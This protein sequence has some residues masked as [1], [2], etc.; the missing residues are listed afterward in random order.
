MIHVNISAIVIHE[1]EKAFSCFYVTVLHPIVFP[2]H[3]YFT[4]VALSCTVFERCGIE[5]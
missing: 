4:A 3:N 5:L 1:T 2:A